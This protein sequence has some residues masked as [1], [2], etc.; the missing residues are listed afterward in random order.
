[1]ECD[2]FGRVASR[3]RRSRED[4]RKLIARSEPCP[5]A[6]RRDWSVERCSDEISRARRARRACNNSSACQPRYKIRPPIYLR[7]PSSTLVQ[8]S[9]LLHS[10]PSAALYCASRYL[11][12][13]YDITRY[14]FD[15]LPPDTS[16]RLYLCL[17]APIR[18]LPDHAPTHCYR[19]HLRNK[20]P[21]HT[22]G[23]FIATPPS[24]CP[25]SC[26]VPSLHH[27]PR[28]PPCRRL[29]PAQPRRRGRST[30]PSSPR[31]TARRTPRPSRATAAAQTS[32]PRP[33]H[34]RR[35]CPRLPRPRSPRRTSS[36][37]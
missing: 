25:A 3:R 9:V 30:H 15:H 20:E 35:L 10:A 27:T 16:I 31:A 23:G 8:P 17:A 1:L 12:P 26:L 4:S 2:C 28:R 24:R 14:H 22:E 32:P 5:G 36:V 34:L 37:R 6:D 13:I 7:V 18:C 11:L 33:P 19:Y 21:R 29:H